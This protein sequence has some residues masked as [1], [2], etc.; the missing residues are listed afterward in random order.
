MR[1]LY[2]HIP[3]CIK[4]CAYCDF[5]SVQASDSVKEAYVNSLLFEMA[6]YK[7][8]NFDTVYIGGGTPT[9]LKTEL[10]KEVINGIKQNFVL[11]VNTEFTV[12]M[13]PK[14][15]NREKLASLNKMGVNRLSI[16]VQSFCDTELKTLGRIH[17]SNDAK[18]AVILAK[19]SGFENISIDLMS[20]IPHQTIDSFSKTL[21]TAISLNPDHIS[22][23]SL[24]LEENTPLYNQVKS[25][26]ITL[27][28]EDTERS[29]YELAVSTLEK[30]GYIQYEISNFAKNGRASRHNIKYWTMEEYVGLGV[31]AHSFFEGRRFA[32]TD[33]VKEY[34]AKNFRKGESESLTKN[35]MMSEFVFLGLRML[36]GISETEFFERFGVTIFEVFPKPIEKFVKTGFLL[37]ENGRIRLSKEAVGVSN[38]IMCEFLL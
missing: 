31:S 15:A 2:I 5:N 8:L 12:E 4:K 14:T 28:D 35:D 30:N 23:Y 37:R 6:E 3:F 34:I 24:I 19:E 9:T 38:Q 7:G 13:N 1:G 16:G 36:E 10:L 11:R 33:S 26:E 25:G 27:C 18:D 20:A 17:N 21:E 22:C 32:N 29:L